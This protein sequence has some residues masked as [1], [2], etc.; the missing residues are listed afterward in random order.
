[1]DPTIQAAQPSQW[2]LA[3]PGVTPMKT[4]VAHDLGCHTALQELGLVK[5]GAAPVGVWGAVKGLGQAAM[6]GV[7]GVGKYM[8]GLMKKQPG[9]AA[10]IIGTGAVGATMVGNR[11]L[12]SSQNNNVNVR[13]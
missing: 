9:M 8:G 2:D 12:N 1:M 6:P 7:T 10:G 13:Y 5:E 3:A 4:N 11:L